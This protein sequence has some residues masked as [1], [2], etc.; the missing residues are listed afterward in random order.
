VPH[1]LT[2]IHKDMTSLLCDRHGHG[3]AVLKHYE[4]LQQRGR[5]SES[6]HHETIEGRR[7]AIHDV[8]KANIGKNEPTLTSALRRVLNVDNLIG[9]TG[10]H[11]EGV[12]CRMTNKE[13][14]EDAV[15]GRLDIVGRSADDDIGQRL[16]LFII[17][18]SVG[19]KSKGG[20]K[21]AGQVFTYATALH[22]TPS[23]AHDGIIYEKSILMATWHSKKISNETAYFD[24]Q[25]FLFMPDV[26]QG[27]TSTSGGKH[28][29]AF[30]WRDHHEGETNEVLSKTTTCLLRFMDCALFLKDLHCGSSA[31]AAANNSNS[32]NNDDD[33]RQIVS[34][35]NSNNSRTTATSDG[36]SDSNNSNNWSDHL[37]R[38][39]EWK[40]LGDN[41]AKVTYKEGLE[42]NGS[43]VWVYKS[44]DNRFFPTDRRVKNWRID[45]V[46][47]LTGNEDAGCWLTELGVETA[48]EYTE[49]QKEDTVWPGSG[50]QTDREGT[51]PVL[52]PFGKGSLVVIRYKHQDG[53]HF[54]WDAHQFLDIA[55]SLRRM[56]DA[57][58]CHG[59]VRG[60]NIVH[61]K[62]EDDA[63]V[64]GSPK[65]RRMENADGGSGS[66]GANA[67]TPTKRTKASVLVDFDLGR[68]IHAGE[69]KDAMSSQYPLGYA[70]WQTDLS[71]KRPGAPKQL[72][73]KAHD[74]QDLGSVMGL[75]EPDTD[76]K[77]FAD[78][79]QD[80]AGDICG[81]TI[82]ADMVE[83]RLKA[84]IQEM[85]DNTR[86]NL[87]RIGQN[88]LG[89]IEKPNFDQTDAATGSP[90][91]HVNKANNQP[92][93]SPSPKRSPKKSPSSSSSSKLPKRSRSSHC[94]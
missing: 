7:K 29:F 65:K 59:D 56:H 86:I 70:S 30:L 90:Y 82:G 46:R 81:G 23:K 13:K 61:Q 6:M 49:G 75:Y 34:T 42:H 67:P 68:I 66:D 24:F 93:R 43:R 16:P 31:A 10:E 87:T 54:A 92:I 63:P 45:D 17:E 8:L 62:Q 76:S 14:K 33:H 94:H 12:I 2:E 20:V 26:D 72:I 55:K 3:L 22:R 9:I 60:F 35:T 69:A 19:D 58:F 73:E 78:K 38:I 89:C 32:H 15:N 28:K 79:W 11:A 21:K 51:R 40:P 77:S 41:V 83:A 53:T 64:N 5:A 80:L 1:F 44:F 18:A 84:F 71:R 74:L 91:K 25:A 4:K 57:G 27:G 39:E 48:F 37:R 50:L 52:T 85:G 47:G 36:D 88:R